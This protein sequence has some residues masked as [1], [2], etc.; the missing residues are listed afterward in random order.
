MIAHYNL[1]AINFRRT[2]GFIDR[3]GCFAW[4]YK[5]CYYYGAAVDSFVELP[6]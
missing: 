2:F 6:G 1:I 5:G 4:R 3:S